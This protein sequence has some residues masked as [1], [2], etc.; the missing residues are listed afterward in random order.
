MRNGCSKKAGAQF[1]HHGGLSEVT[2]ANAPCLCARASSQQKMISTAISRAQGSRITDIGA[3]A[4]FVA[5]LLAPN[6]SQ[7]V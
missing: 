1:I 4:L 3:A 5:L 6:V 2:S 7:Y